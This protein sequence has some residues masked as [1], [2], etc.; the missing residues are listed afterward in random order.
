MNNYSK[1]DVVFHPIEEGKHCFDHWYVNFY[2]IYDN[3]EL[4]AKVD[5]NNSKVKFKQIRF[6]PEEYNECELVEVYDDGILICSP[7]TLASEQN[8]FFVSDKGITC[9]NIKFNDFYKAIKF[10]KKEHIRELL[11]FTQNI[12]EKEF[13][14]SYSQENLRKMIAAGLPRSIISKILNSNIQHKSGLSIEHLIEV[15]KK[16]AID[17]LIQVYDAG[18]EIVKYASVKELGED[19]FDNEAFGYFLIQTY[20]NGKSNEMFVQLS[21][22][23]VIAGCLD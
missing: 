7:H 4:I 21:D 6:E 16:S 18:N 11:G 5:I 2:E 3:D 9:K 13:D 15:A 20:K 19:N 10:A 17:D 12:S 1:Y 23:S 14:H 22:G 8:Y